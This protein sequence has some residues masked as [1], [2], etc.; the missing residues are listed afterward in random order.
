MCK[1]T[2][3]VANFLNLIL[4]FDLGDY[5]SLYG[6]TIR[7]CL[8]NWRVVLSIMNQHLVK[9]LPKV[10]FTRVVS[11]FTVIGCGV[12]VTCRCAAVL[13][14]PCGGVHVLEPSGGPRGGW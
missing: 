4:G 10:K 14:P 1:L 12:G 5:C 13:G 6:I 7:S 2:E 3:V 11:V 9:S 8:L